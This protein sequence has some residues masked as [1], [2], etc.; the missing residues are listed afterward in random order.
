MKEVIRFLIK[1]WL[2]NKFLLLIPVVIILFIVA[3][4][5]INSTQSGAT[6]QELQETFQSRKENVNLLIN[7]LLTKERMIGLTMNE[8]HALDSLL[9]KEE[10]VKEILTKLNDGNLQIADEQL[11]YIKQYRKYITYKPIPYLNEN[12]LKDEELKAQVLKEHQ[13]SYSEQLTPYKTALFTKQLLQILFSP[14]TAFL[15]LLMFCY[16]YI[17]DKEKRTFDFFKINSLSNLAIYYGYL[18]PLLLNVLLYIFIVAFVSFLPPLLTGNLDT[19]FYPLEVAVNNEIILVPVWKWLVFVP[20]GWGIFMTL[21]LLL[22]TCLF[23]QRATLG[24]LFTFISLPALIGYMISLKFGFHMANPIHLIVSYEANILAADHF[25]AYIVGMLC[26]LVVCGIVSY[27]VIRAKNIMLRFSEFQTTKK[28]VQLTGKLKLLKFEH[29]KKKRKGHIFLTLILLLGT[30]G[31]TAV[32]VNQQFQTIPT[33]ALKV[34]ENSQNMIIQQRTQWELLLAEFEIEKERQRLND[35]TEI[36]DGNLHANAIKQLDNQYDLLESLKNE[37]HSKDFSETFRKTMKSPEPGSY[38]DMDSANWTVTEIAS[39]EQQNSLDD[40]GITPWPLGHKWVSNFDDPSQ[41]INNEHLEILKLIQERNTKYD[42]SSLFAIYKYFDWNVMF[43]VL[44]IFILLLWTTVS[45]EYKPTSTINFLISK[46]IRFKSIYITKW[47]YNL[48]IAYSLL[49]ISGVLI[50]LVATMIGGVGE[51]KYPILVYATDRAND[52][53][54]FSVPNNCYFYFENLITLIL[55]SGFLILAQIF[56][57]NSLF[58]LI[59]KWTKNH[60]VSIVVTLILFIAG[61]SLGNHYITMSG[62]VYNPFIYFDT[63]NIVDGWKSIE[64]SSRNVNFLNG[65]GILLISGSLLF[66]LGFLFR[67]KV[68]G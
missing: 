45:D 8:E 40:Q 59:G 11:A 53:Y 55:K 67:G 27:I 6:E 18:I 28:R 4:A 22:L 10:Y 20:I 65:I 50:F 15:L 52:A 19:I 30:I 66:C 12:A 21:L 68:R 2:K 26:L 34:I 39:E 35:G 54:F 38:K 24:T 23:K 7:S 43:F 46:P 31:G 29:L 63:W 41:A 9:L 33:K 47:A 14:I 1:G 17:S 44:L 61:Y 49:L 36:D 32:V 42:N 58:S 56:F 13:L 62:N 25:V 51:A 16:R 5:V 64:A 48:M 37:I 57:L 3:L 60:Y